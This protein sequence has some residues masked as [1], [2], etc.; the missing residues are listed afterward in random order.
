M[1]TCFQLS[2]LMTLAA[3]LI[4]AC[5]GDGSSSS[6]STSTSTD[7]TVTLTAPAA[8]TA[9]V[10]TAG[11]ASA[12]IAFSAPASNGGSSITSYTASCTGAGVTKTGAGGAS[13]ITVA[14]LANA[15][16]YSCSVTATNAQG[17]GV[18]SSSVSVTPTAGTSSGT[19]SGSTF[20]LTSAAAV[21]GTLPAEYTCDGPASTP[22]LAWSNAPSGTTEFAVLMTTL[23][24]DG[25]TKYN[26]VLYGIPA[27][28]TSLA[29]DSYGVGT[30]GVGSDGP[31]VAYQP[32][33]SQG[34]GDKTYTFT[35]YALSASP[36]V[37][38]ST[39]V[40]GAA[41]AAAMPSIT[42]G[43]AALSLSYNRVA[44]A[45]GLGTNCGLVTS[46]MKA[47]TTGA[48][49]VGCDSTYAYV[50][51]SGLATHTMMDGITASNLQMPLGQ[52][53]YG[54]NAWKIP[55]NPA[56]ASTTTTAADGPIG[57]AINGVPIFNPCKQGGC[58]N[59]DT[60]VLGEL[61][62]CNGHAGR[63]D[64]Y[65]YHAAPTCLMAGKAS[66]Y[67]DTHP[68]GWALDGFGVYGY[69]NA[70][71]T[72]ATR[73]GVCGGNTSA[74]TGSPAGYS[75]HVTDSSPY[76]LSC[77]RGTPSP[78]LAGQ[79]AKYSPIR[80]PP[81]TPF[82][83]AAMTLTTDATD[84]YQVLQFSSTRSFVSTE[85]GTDSYT[86]A[87]GTYRIRFKPVTGAALVTLLASSQNSG[88]SACWNFQF[89]NS[90][91][92]TT[93]PTVSYCR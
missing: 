28:K 41:L 31:I 25:S 19:P 37:S 64:D 62:V 93:Q 22:A 14:S 3:L 84:G 26:W 65:H 52:K 49:S 56:V 38:S 86:N 18:A 46:S 76:V 51:S 91:G 27:S 72:V 50:A 82:P 87:A 83:V 92:S 71:G 30:L 35:V 57:V 23:P 44:T 81:V 10:A 78:D 7:T 15:S 77:F 61:D 53:F 85:T 89:T 33:C 13:P 75:Y 45:G 58:Q 88:K 80:Q 1:K 16:V 32:P 73:D 48:A 21:S 54:S 6:T 47:S 29:K 11:N 42:L 79:G 8:P 67:W 74:V 63:A 60:K 12:S 17:T 2:A 70:D 20:S 69:N 5:G 34:L 66:S 40:S 43:T 36:A 90:G 55:L 68:L 4:A 9:L 59:G 39:A 24:G